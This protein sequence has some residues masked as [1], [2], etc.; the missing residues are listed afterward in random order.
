MQCNECNGP[1]E[2][3]IPKSNPGAAEHYCGNCHRSHPVDGV[4]VDAEWNGARSRGQNV[5]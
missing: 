1:C 4:T 3:L 5:A 2:T